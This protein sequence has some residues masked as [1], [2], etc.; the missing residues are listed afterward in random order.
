MS[1]LA[2]KN[3][4]GKQLLE[5]FCLPNKHDIVRGIILDAL[6]AYERR[7]IARGVDV[8]VE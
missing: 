1:S 6:S 5:V 4:I 8:A 3:N 7:D 2:E